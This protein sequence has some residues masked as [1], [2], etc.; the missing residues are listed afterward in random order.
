MQAGTGKIQSMH[1][2]GEDVRLQISVT[3]EEGVLTGSLN[4][5][6]ALEESHDMDI[7]QECKVT[8]DFGVTKSA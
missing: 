7:G 1:Q 6:V 5:K 3:A 8:V 4:Q 2:E